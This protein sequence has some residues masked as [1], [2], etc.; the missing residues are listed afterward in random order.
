MRAPE[1][2]GDG[3]FARLGGVC[4]SVAREQLVHPAEGGED[5]LSWPAR[6]LVCEQSHRLTRRLLQHTAHGNVCGWR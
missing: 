3:V 5:L 6:G 1:A 2:A 4:A